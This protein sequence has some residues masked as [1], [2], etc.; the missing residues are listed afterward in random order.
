MK[1]ILI[2]L[3]SLALIS[4]MA[5]NAA[6]VKNK[7]VEESV[8]FAQA[9][10]A[11]S[12]L[13]SDIDEDSY[14]NQTAGLSEV[15]HGNIRDFLSES[16]KP[17]RMYDVGSYYFLK[18]NEI[19]GDEMEHDHIP[20]SKA[21][22]KYVSRTLGEE[23]APNPR[24][25]SGKNIHKNATAIEITKILHSKGRTYRGK[26]TASQIELDSQDLKI[27]TLKDMSYHLVNSGFDIE[28]LEPFR[29]MY[30]RNSAMCL[31]Q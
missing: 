8:D 24:S 28:L 13:V 19:V 29:D 25:A 3:L 26:N 9:Y 10:S 31:Y 7:E 18:K 15:A 30:I 14:C 23:I 1:Y 11:L 21:V 27:A 6:S 12:K 16:K 20:S 17:V 4:P 22:S 2:S 5:V